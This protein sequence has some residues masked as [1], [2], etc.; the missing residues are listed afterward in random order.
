M[1]QKENSSI[2][3]YLLRLLGGYLNVTAIILFS[4]VVGGQTGNISKIAIAYVEG[5]FNT[6]FQLVA[7][8]F[9]FMLG[10]FISGLLKP[11][12]RA[13]MGPRYGFLFVGIGLIFV[14]FSIMGFNSVFFLLY[15]VLVLGATNGITLYCKGMVVKTTIITGTLTDIGITLS[16]TFKGASLDKQ[17]LTFHFL[18]LFCFLLGATLAAFIGIRTTWNMVSIAGLLE[19]VIGFYFV[20]LRE[21]AFGTEKEGTL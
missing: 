2:W 4:R 16:E 17:K 21:V 19:L 14:L 5:N 9:T 15:L 12:D 20:S 6:V 10:G 8:A 3:V 13:E 1:H 7:I 18:N 11:F